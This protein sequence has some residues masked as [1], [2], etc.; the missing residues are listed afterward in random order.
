MAS[1]TERRLSPTFPTKATL[2]SGRKLSAGDLVA[3]DTLV[4]AEGPL[5]GYLVAEGERDALYLLFLKAKAYSAGVYREGTLRPLTIREFF[6]LL[7]DKGGCERTFD[8]FEVDP[9]VLLLIAVHFQKRPL[10]SVSTDLANPAEVLGKVEEGGRDA[11]IALVDGPLRHVVFCQKGRPVRF[12]AAGDVAVP[13]EDSLDE[14]IT[15]FCFERGSKR[16]ITLEVYDDLEQSPAPDRGVPLARY[17]ALGGNVPRYE[18]ARFEGASLVETRM[19]QLERCVIGRT[20]GTDFRIDDASVSREHAAIQ[21]EKGHLVLRDLGSDNGT[22]VNNEKLDGPCQL[23]ADDEIRVGRARLIF[24][25]LPNA[26][27]SGDETVQLDSSTLGAR[28]MHVGQVYP[29]VE[30]GLVLGTGGD[31][32]IRLSGFLVRPHQLRVFRGADGT[33]WIEHLGGWRALTINGKPTRRS[34]LA[35]GDAIRMAGETLRFYDTD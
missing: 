6:S 3:I 33:Y 9:A 20:D 28:L 4:G 23:R 34:Q 2:F 13:R 35:T 25:P 14:V 29:V 32:D 15:I 12:H 17:A 1:D 26:G 7:L 11:I 19:V 5:A 27:G 8:L 30:R 24:R 22:W 21:L 10:L 18:L 31:A 16:P